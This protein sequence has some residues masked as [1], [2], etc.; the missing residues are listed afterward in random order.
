MSLLVQ[1]Y[2]REPGTGQI[3][4]LAL[5]P[6]SE[7][8]DLAGFEAWRDQI[9]AGPEARALGLKVL[10]RLANDDIYAEG[11]ELL[12]LERE[13]R[14]LLGRYSSEEF[15]SVAFRLLNILEAIRVA[16]REPNGGVYIG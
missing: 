3:R 11:T 7:R 14:A 2:C 1:A 16:Q 15:E 8:N 12:T 5:E 13:T 6:D 10:P 4:W 9:Y